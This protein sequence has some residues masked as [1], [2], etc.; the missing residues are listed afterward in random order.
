M[1]GWLVGVVLLLCR[2]EGRPDEDLAA[3]FWEGVGHDFGRQVMSKWQEQAIWLQGYWLLSSGK[4]LPTAKIVHKLR[5][6]V[7][8]VQVE[9]STLSV[10]IPRELKR[11]F[12]T[13]R[14]RWIVAVP[15]FKQVTNISDTDDRFRS[16]KA[17]GIITTLQMTYRPAPT[18]LPFHQVSSRSAVNNLTR[19]LHTKTPSPKNPTTPVHQSTPSYLSVTLACRLQLCL[20]SCPNLELPSA[21]SSHL[22]HPHLTKFYSFLTSSPHPQPQML[23][24]GFGHHLS[25]FLSA[26]SCPLCLP[27]HSLF[28][29]IVCQGYQC[30]AF[31]R[32]QYE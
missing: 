29:Q 2:K 27:L 23:M 4:V 22:G 18:A 9:A 17:W 24:G 32:I 31:A 25:L 21:S 20:A 16:S 10:A 11:N 7:G 26:S 14:G 19:C 13:K 1:G 12:R 30:N 6:T 28:D 3:R 15:W 5:G 8:G